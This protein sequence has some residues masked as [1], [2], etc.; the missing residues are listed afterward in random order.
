[1]RMPPRKPA[2][3]LE[4]WWAWGY[5][6]KINTRR[7]SGHKTVS[8]GWNYIFQNPVRHRR[9][10]HSSRRA[11]RLVTPN[12]IN[13]RPYQDLRSHLLAIWENWTS[14][15]L[16]ETQVDWGRPWRE[17]KVRTMIINRTFESLGS[18]L[19][20][21]GRDEKGNARPWFPDCS[22]VER[23]SFKRQVPLDGVRVW[24]QI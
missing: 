6:G 23:N 5:G 21:G 1:M 18:A 7:M 4:P 2:R 12:A 16:N 10:Y 20:W 11:Y 8:K 17:D 24:S 9:T 19:E 3:S 22:V 14:K 13:P 15:T